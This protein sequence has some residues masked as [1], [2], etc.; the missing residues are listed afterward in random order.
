MST[1]Q[2]KVGTILTI[3]LSLLVIGSS[4]SKSPDVAPPTN[5]AGSTGVAY[6]AGDGSVAG[7]I[8]YNG[9]PPTRRRSTRQPMPLATS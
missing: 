1:K 3:V 4:C 6:T 7:A 9:T 8:A 5:D 2:L